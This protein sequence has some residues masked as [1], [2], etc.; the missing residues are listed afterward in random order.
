MKIHYEG[1]NSKWDTWCDYKSET[2]RFAAPR[3]IS[4][5]PNTRFRDLKILDYVDI[6]PIQRH[7]GWRVGQIRRM[8]KYSGQAQMCIRKMD[9]SSYIGRI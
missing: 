2:H 4:R 8:D 1:W 7:R 5:K 9:R 6:N 3:S